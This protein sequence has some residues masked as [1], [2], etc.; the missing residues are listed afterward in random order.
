MRIKKRVFFFYRNYHP[1]HQDQMSVLITLLGLDVVRKLT[2]ACPDC[3]TLAIMFNV[4]MDLKSYY[5]KHKTER[6]RKSSQSSISFYF[7]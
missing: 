2:F 3:G 4:P 7:L 5:A 6:C 1:E